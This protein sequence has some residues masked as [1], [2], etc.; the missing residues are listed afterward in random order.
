MITVFSGVALAFVAMLGWGIGDFTIQKSTRKIG[1]LE[2]IFVIT[3]F[4]VIVLLP[5]AYTGISG[6]FDDLKS[7]AILGGS[8]VVLLSAALF[9]LEGFKRGKISVLEPIMSLEILAASTLAFFFL[10]DRV[11]G[12]QIAS[13][14][15]LMVGL[16]LISFREARLSHRIFLEKG[17]LIFVCGAV[18]MGAAD[19]LLGWGSRETDPVLA[20]FVLSLILCMA[21]GSTLL[22][23]GE[24][25]QTIRDVSKYPAL[26]LV[27]CVSDNLAWLAYA[28]AM[29][30]VPIAVATGLSES[31]IIVAV[32]LGLF[33]NKEKIQRHQKVGLVVSIAAVLTLAA[34]TA[35]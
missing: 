11:S 30:L 32:L 20:N 23:R 22:V 25:G 2:T 9:Q 17:V 19:F 4:G 8:G 28:V 31:S 10:G 33:V 15:M 13:I 35:K 3:L 29:T 16:F 21:T 7:L 6:L 1:D 27:M 14:L 18:L 24:L 12:G 5:F 34:L 26:L